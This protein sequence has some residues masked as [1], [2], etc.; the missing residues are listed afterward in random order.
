MKPCRGTLP[1]QIRAGTLA[2]A[3]LRRERLCLRTGRWEASVS[4]E[5]HA[6]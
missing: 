5:S 4:R 1:E 3:R 2:R 6:G